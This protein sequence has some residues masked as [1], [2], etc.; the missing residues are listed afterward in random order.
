M[1]SSTSKEGDVAPF[2]TNY[3]ED[4]KGKDA[5]SI[6]HG[7]A[8]H[9]ITVP[10]RTHSQLL[11]TARLLPVPPL[12]YSSRL[13]S[14][15]PQGTSPTPPLGDGRQVQKIPEN[16]WPVKELSQYCIKMEQKTTIHDSKQNKVCAHLTL[17]VPHITCWDFALFEWV[18]WGHSQK[19]QASSNPHGV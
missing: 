8:W 16:R 7:K 9:S 13:S 6:L 18:N 15:T 3:L 5:V 2:T 1:N 10:P 19:S 14:L 4:P 12:L 17:D 11:S